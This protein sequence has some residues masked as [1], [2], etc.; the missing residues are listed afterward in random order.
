MKESISGTVSTPKIAVD[1]MGGDFAPGSVVKGAVLASTA[2]GIRVAL[3]GHEEKIREELEKSGGSPHHI[4]IHHAPEVIEMGEEAFHLIRKKRHASL[5]VAFEMVR[6]NEAHALVSAGNS[7]AVVYGALFILK[8]LKYIDRPGIGIIMPSL[9]GKVMVIDAG[10]NTICKPQNLVQFAIMGSSYCRHVLGLGHPKVGVL[11]NG[12][13][14]TKGTEL[15]RLANELLKKSSLNYIGY[16]EGRDVFN[17]KV[18]VV[19]CDGFVGNVLLKV[20]EGVS[21]SL[22]AALKEEIGKRSLSKLGYLLAKKSFVNFKKRFDYSEYGGAPLLGVNKPVILG[23]GTS[24]ANAI[25]NAVRMAHNLVLKNITHTLTEEL[26]ESEDLISLK[27]THIFFNKIFGGVKT[28]PK[29]ES[30]EE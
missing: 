21:E 3:V 10:A 6:D 19:V 27:K 9:S 24:N 22:V 30:M 5:R 7:G 20:S 23:H 29:P 12:E 14:E 25:M 16:V 18:D 1:A 11:S 2:H 17:G 13:E 4:E 26:R 15:T 28:K 8:R